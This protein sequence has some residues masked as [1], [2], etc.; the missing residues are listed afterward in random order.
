MLSPFKG[1]SLLPLRSI[2]EYVPVSET[3]NAGFCNNRTF[4]SVLYAKGNPLLAAKEKEGNNVMN[5]S[6]NRSGNHFLMVSP[7]VDQALV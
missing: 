6:I 3:E 4:T 1:I 5:A 2:N 7:I